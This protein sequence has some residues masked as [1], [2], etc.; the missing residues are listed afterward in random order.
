M[1]MPFTSYYFFIS[2]IIRTEM[3]IQINISFLSTASDQQQIFLTIQSLEVFV[4]SAI[5][6]NY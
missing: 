2:T 4:Q 6:I 3:K 1:L 5:I